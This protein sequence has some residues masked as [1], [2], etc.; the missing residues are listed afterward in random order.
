MK[1]ILAYVG[2][3]LAY[4]YMTLVGRTSRFRWEGLEHVRMLERQG[5]NFIYAF[6]HNRQVLFTYTHRGSGVRI[7]VSRSRDGEIIAKTMALS[8]IEAVRGSSSRGS[9]ATTREMIDLVSSGKRVGITPDGPKGPA[10]A[11][12]PGILYLAQKTGLPIIPISNATS[13]K[14]IFRKSWDQFQVPLPL[15]QCAVVHG[16]PLHVAEGD[17]IDAKAL[18]LAQSLDRITA[19]AE[20][21]VGK[22]S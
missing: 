22:K 13:R 12:K 16:P 5:K 15:A 8:R 17:A 21:F 6:W 4:G 11:V 18:E 3:Y 2:P 9:L 20:K 1:S 7:L 19:E 10:G 14:I